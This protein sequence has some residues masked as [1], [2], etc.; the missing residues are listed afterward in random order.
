MLTSMNFD[1][2]GLVFVYTH[3]AKVSFTESSTMSTVQHVMQ[4]ICFPLLWSS[5]P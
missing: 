1:I 2:L 5:N 3:R 4:K